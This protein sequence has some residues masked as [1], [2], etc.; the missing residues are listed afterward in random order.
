MNLKFDEIYTG[1]WNFKS[2]DGV[3]VHFIG[4]PTDE[5]EFVQLLQRESCNPI[6]SHLICDDLIKFGE[7]K[8]TTRSHLDFNYINKCLNLI[9]VRIEIIPPVVADHHYDFSNICS[10][11]IMYYLKRKISLEESEKYIKFVN[12]DILDKVKQLSEYI[13]D[14]LERRPANLKPYYFDDDYK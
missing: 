8:T 9:G 6:I 12:D 7:R 4:K 3:G 10:K 14:A 11:A 5:I 1:E 2:H 13:E